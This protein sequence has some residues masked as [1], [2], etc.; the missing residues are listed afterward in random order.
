MISDSSVDRNSR[1]VRA[2][3]LGRIR[4]LIVTNHGTFRGWVRGALSQ[5]DFTFG[6]LDR[7][8]QPAPRQVRRLVFVC[9]GNINRSALAGAVASQ[10]N[11]RSVSIG[12]STSTGAPATSAAVRCAAAFGVD[13]TQHAATDISDYDFEP[14]DL[15][16]VMETRHARRL[17]IR[18]IAPDAIAL[19]GHWASPH[20]IHLHDPHTLPDRYFRSCFTLIS[21]AVN[22]LIDE[23]TLAGSPCTARIA[24]VLTGV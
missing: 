9:L 13:L 2:S 15:L 23:L 22:N 17:I 10:R 20:R 19:L 14:G 21:S 24:Q 11:V 6:G 7:F 1:T 18:G 12:L 8:V 5:I 4:F 3:F 16:L